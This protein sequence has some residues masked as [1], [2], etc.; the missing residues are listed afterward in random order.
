MLKCTD[1][2]G[3]KVNKKY[4]FKST[5]LCHIHYIIILPGHS[6]KHGLHSTG[7]PLQNL[8]PWAGFGSVQ[9][10]TR[11]CFPVPHDTVQVPH[12]DQEDHWPSV[13]ITV[14]IRAK[15]EYNIVCD[16][17]LSYVMAST[18]YFGLIDDDICFVLD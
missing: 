9:V 8:P 16:C 14:N 2:S 18:S 3:H 12:S 1:I 4:I 11:L 10:L 6:V 5:L 15:Y 13:G 7:Y 17:F